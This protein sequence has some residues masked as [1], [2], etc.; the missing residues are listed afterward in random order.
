MQKMIRYGP[1]T[2]ALDK[3]QHVNGTLTFNNFPAMYALGLES[4]L[5]TRLYATPFT[6]AG[7][8]KQGCGTTTTVRL[9]DYPPSVTPVRFGSSLSVNP[10]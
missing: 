4:D 2:R 6:E 1:N 9:L 5:V 3:Y 10:A 7:D 8:H